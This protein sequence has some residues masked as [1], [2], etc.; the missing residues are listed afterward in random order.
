ME[1]DLAFLAEDVRSTF[2]DIDDELL[3]PSGDVE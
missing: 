2:L 1:W 3:G